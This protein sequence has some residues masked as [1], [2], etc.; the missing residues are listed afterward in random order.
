MDKSPGVSGSIFLQ[1]S[2]V[3]WLGSIVP[4]FDNNLQ[5]PAP[6][7][8]SIDRLSFL[9]CR[10]QQAPA[11]Q[12][13]PS[14]ALGFTGGMI[15]EADK[16]RP[17]T[18]RRGGHEI[19]TGTDK[20]IMLHPR[21]SKLIIL[22]IFLIVICNSLPGTYLATVFLFCLSHTLNSGKFFFK[23]AMTKAYLRFSL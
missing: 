4:G 20:M 9:L 11:P 22:D 14:G 7:H 23:H 8:V 19:A 16:Q 3:K 18:G 5:V 12:D 17:E 2:D 1:C 6:S 15:E 10:I 13:H 21:L